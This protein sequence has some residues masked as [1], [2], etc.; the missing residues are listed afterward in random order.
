MSGILKLAARV[1]KP[2]N[3]AREEKAYLHVNVA[4]RDVDL[5][6]LLK[7]AGVEVP[8]KVAGK[9]TVRVQVDIPT[10]TPDE[11]KAYRLT[12]TV[13]SKRA[14]VDELA[15]EDVSAEVDFRDGKLSVKEFV[16]KLP[17][18]ATPA[19]EAGSFRARGEMDVGKSLSVQGD[20]QARQGAARERRAA[21]QPGAGVVAAG[22]G[23]ERPR[24]PG[25]HAEP[26]RS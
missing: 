25:G 5:A 17:G 11:F 4:F 18:F 15:V 21:P 12:G 2:V 24:Q 10:E 16:G 9:V 20:G 13:Q 7:T 3:A 26:G 14:T 23:G 19:G 6:E 8:V 1:V 22:R